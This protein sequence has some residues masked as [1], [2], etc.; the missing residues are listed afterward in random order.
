MAG[1]KQGGACRRPLDHPLIFL[2]KTFMFK[3]SAFY[4]F[5]PLPKGRLKAL[6]QALLAKGRERRIRGLALLAEEGINAALTGREADLELFKGEISRLLQKDFFYKESFS[7]SWCFRRLSVKVKSGIVNMGKAFAR[8]EEQNHHLSPEEWERRLR[9]A[10][11]LLDARNIYE[12]RIGRFKGAED[13]GLKTFSEFP[14]KISSWR[15]DKDKETLIYCTGGIRCE[16]AIEA[17]KARGFK[18]VFQLRGGILNYLKTCPRSRFEGECFVFDHR[19]AVDQ[20]L[21]PS[22]QYSLCARCGQPGREPVQCAR[23]GS[24]AIVC[25]ACLQGPSRHRFCSKD[26]AYHFKKGRRFKK[27]PRAAAAGAAK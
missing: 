27:R 16:K 7:G 22:R 5:F 6:R 17:M 15:G 20:S 14:E 19:A 23:C 11:Q 2:Y 26:C 25:S 4:K 18:K 24:A 13:L 1:G 9:G 12:A 10:P 3:V 8:P 21:R